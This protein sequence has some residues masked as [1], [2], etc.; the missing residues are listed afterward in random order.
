MTDSTRAREGELKSIFDALEEAF[1]ALQIDFY[2]IGALARDIWYARNKK[3]S[4]KTKDIDLA[5]FIASK[6]DYAALRNF[7]VDKKNFIE[8][9]TNSY[10]IISPEGLPI[11]L[12]PFGE[13]EIDEQVI[14]PGHGLTSIRVNGFKEVYQ[15]GTVTLDL[16]T[17]HSLK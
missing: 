11:D 17:G 9:S 1:N 4:R 14:L 5:V 10:V 3:E 15:L 6:E 12:L 16:E 13:I 8:S 2:I 7:L